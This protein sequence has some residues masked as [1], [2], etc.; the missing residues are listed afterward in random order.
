[1][2]LLCR[3][4]LSVMQAN[5]LMVTPIRGQLESTNRLM[6]RAMFT[7]AGICTTA[8]ISR[9]RRCKGRVSSPI[10]HSESICVH[11]LDCDSVPQQAAKAVPW[12]RDHRRV[13][14]IIPDRYC[15]GNV[16]ISTDLSCHTLPCSSPRRTI[17]RRRNSI[18]KISLART[19][20]ANEDGSAVNDS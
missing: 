10:K 15:S 7:S 5:T 12:R 6:R 18:E 11:Y 1:M 4:V 17:Q 13:S 16:V 9:S 20:R 8:V 14:G 2:L 3:S 19:Q